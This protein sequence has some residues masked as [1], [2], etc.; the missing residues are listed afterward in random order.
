M[1]RG[2]KNIPKAFPTWDFRPVTATGIWTCQLE[3]TTENWRN[4]KEKIKTK[5]VRNEG[6]II[7]QLD[8]G[9]YIAYTGGTPFFNT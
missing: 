4:Y 7:Y 9:A 6:L 1:F 3:S 5:I 8:E 2:A